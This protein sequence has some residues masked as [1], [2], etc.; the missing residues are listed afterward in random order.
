M[1]AA[2]LF[3]SPTPWISSGLRHSFR[4]ALS[5]HG[6]PCRF[7]NKAGDHSNCPRSF[8]QTSLT[9]A[10][11][12][13]A[14]LC[15]PHTASGQTDRVRTNIKTK[16][17]TAERELYAGNKTPRE[18]RREA[19]DQAQA[20]AVRKAIGTQVQAQQRSSTIERGE[21]VVNRFSQIVRTGS[22]GRVTDFEVLE[23]KLRSKNGTIYQYV[24]IR[25]T[26]QPTAGRPDPGFVV[27]LQLTD[28][29]RTFVARDSREKSD[30]II[31]KVEVTKDAN[32]TLFNVT[33]DTLQ[34]IWPNS[35]STDTSIPAG[36]MVEF[37]PPNLRARGFHLRVE[38]PEDRRQI[39]ERL[40]AVATKKRV[41]FQ[42]VPKRQIENGT[43]ETA[44][45]SVQTLNRWLVDIPLGQRA[46]QSV[47]YDVVQPDEQ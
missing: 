15:G 43:L 3:L 41:P 4:P 14:V 44:Q 33:P 30:E 22:S 19:I 26:V 40:V 21:E 1:S 10:L 23:E 6:S 12:I 35:L 46:I 37:P 32:L 29:D 17:V 47:T 38:L 7:H 20:E 25:A 34:V 45:A 28:D 9:A 13:A 27:S 39:T 42:E 36:T 5:L 11:L 31:A 2:S 18:A 8:R 24:R 16:T